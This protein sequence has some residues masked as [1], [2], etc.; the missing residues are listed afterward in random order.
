MEHNIESDY[1]LHIKMVA[2]KL[3]RVCQ[4]LIHKDQVG[5]VPNRSLFDHTRL[6]NLMVDY[7][8]KEGQNGYIISLDQEKGYDKIDH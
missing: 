6:A 4:K 5:F 1:M 2:N 7:A 8:E 3:R